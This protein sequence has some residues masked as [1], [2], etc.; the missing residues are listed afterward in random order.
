VVSLLDGI[1]SPTS[2]V[3]SI[4]ASKCGL[5]G[6]LRQQRVQKKVMRHGAPMQA[7][8]KTGA[9]EGDGV[10]DDGRVVEG[11]CEEGVC[12]GF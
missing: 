6:L 7:R 2:P 5:W 9:E 10:E 12:F 3:P 1:R 4:G 11:I 8:D